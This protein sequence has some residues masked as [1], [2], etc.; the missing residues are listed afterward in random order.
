VNAEK[1]ENSPN[2]DALLDSILTIFKIPLLLVTK[3]LKCK[4]PLGKMPV[5]SQRKNDMGAREE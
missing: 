3:K 4:G 2:P 1:K 5:G